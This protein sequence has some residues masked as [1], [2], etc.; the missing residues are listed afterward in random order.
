MN[1]LKGKKCIETER[2]NDRNDTYDNDVVS[3]FSKPKNDALVA[4]LFASFT[5]HSEAVESV[6]EPYLNKLDDE[7]DKLQTE[8]DSTEIS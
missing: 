8:N 3:L 4:E 7:S 1:F 6:A 5:K 2:K